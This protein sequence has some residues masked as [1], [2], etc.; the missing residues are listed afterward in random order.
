MYVDH[1][2]PE[3]GAEPDDRQQAELRHVLM[4]D[5]VEFVLLDQILRPRHLDDEDAVLAQP[6][7]DAGHEVME[8]ADM[9]ERVCRDDHARRA[10]FLGAGKALWRR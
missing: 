5:G 6:F 2:Q 10:V 3:I 7:R 8:V 4:I 1:F 9:V